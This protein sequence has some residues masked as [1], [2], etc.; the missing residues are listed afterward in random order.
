MTDKQ[1]KNKVLRLREIYREE[2]S[3]G[4]SD[5]SFVVWVESV[6]RGEFGGDE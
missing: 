2:F 4:D 5:E 1:L 6:L 3:N